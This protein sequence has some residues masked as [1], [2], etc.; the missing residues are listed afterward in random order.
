MDGPVEGR[1]PR[2]AFI[3]G[4]AW[5][6]VAAG[7]I[8]ILAAAMTALISAVLPVEDMRAV[9]R[10]AEKTQ[11]M[12]ALVGAVVENFRLVAWL[13]LATGVVTLVS[14]IGLLNRRNWARLM[15]VWMMALAAVAHLAGAAAPFLAGPA[16]VDAATGLVVLLSIVLAVLFGWLV[17]RLLSDGVRQEFRAPGQ[18]GL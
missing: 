17:K 4:L 18:A 9:L 5:T 15:F 1:T 10:E 11:P 2:S 14:S 16:A 8:A 6:S 3:T 12:P 7:V 13:F